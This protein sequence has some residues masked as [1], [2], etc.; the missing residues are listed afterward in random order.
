MKTIIGIGGVA[1]AGKDTL[2]SLLISELSKL[3]I[4]GKRYA[5]ADVLKNELNPTLIKEYG[6]D[7]WNC[8]PTQKEIVRPAL[9]DYGRKK[10]LETN[11]MYWVDALDKIVRQENIEIP[12]ISDIRYANEVNWIK[13]AF[14]VKGYII[15]VSR[16]KQ[17]SAG[18]T[19]VDHIDLIPPSNEEEAKNDPQVQ[20]QS[21]FTII[22]PTNPCT[23]CLKG[24]AKKVIEQ[25]KI[26]S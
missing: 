14:N 11:G 3:G 12:I 18:V 19:H 6:I 23:Q 2:T 16:I 15:H 20:Q 8:N 17:H 24:Y 5:L 22:W 7:I 21:D 4:Q 9:V 10:R 26:G 25:L 13:K 1:R